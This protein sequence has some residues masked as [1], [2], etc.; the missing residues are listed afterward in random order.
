VSDAQ[1]RKLLYDV[2]RNGK[3]IG[4]INFVEMVSGP[5]KFLSMTSDVK[6]RFIFAFSDDTAETAAYDNGV[7]V[8][9]SF[10]QK[11]TGSGTAT[12][13]TIAAGKDYKLTDDGKSKLAKFDPIRYNML[14]LY[15]TVPEAI[16]KVYSAN[17]QKHLDIEK[18]E[19]NKYRLTMPDGKF[20]YYTYKN[21]VCTMV[22]IVRSLF[23]LQFVL[24]DI[25]AKVAG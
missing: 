18:I 1:E 23:T 8:Y 7:M 3:V 10:Y 11:Q 25:T 9:S 24:K 16:S 15:T 17:F 14:L 5:K 21:G 2:M 20:N 22:E 6:T 13:T 12:K 4:K 19:D